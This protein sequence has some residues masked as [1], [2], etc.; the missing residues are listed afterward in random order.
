MAKKK[1]ETAPVADPVPVEHV[2]KQYQFTKENAAAAQAKGTVVREKA[3]VER[4]IVKLEAT[5]E[6]RKRQD[7]IAKLGLTKVMPDVDRDQ[8]PQIALSIIADHGLRVLGGEWEIKS[9]EEA[10]KIGKVWHDIFRL[11][12]GEPTTISS[13]QESESPDQR[14]NRFEELKLEAKRRVEGGLRAI[15]GDAG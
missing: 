5:E 6:Y 15:A 9:A 11:E 4:K 10:T 13:S 8:L 14:K 12:M 1:T 2:L 3:A 7:Q